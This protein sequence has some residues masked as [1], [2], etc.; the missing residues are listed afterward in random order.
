[1][2]SGLLST[3]CARATPGL[4]TD[5]VFLGLRLC[6]GLARVVQ[7]VDVVGFPQGGDGISITTGIVS[8]IDWGAYSHSAERNHIVVRDLEIL[9][10][11]RVVCKV[12]A[13]IKYVPC[14]LFT[15]DRRR[16][17]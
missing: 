16:S 9:L 13:L 7:A 3:S 4:N 14:L 2:Q 11:F 15:A 1:M 5:C 8:R 10:V 6:V 17:D 12:S